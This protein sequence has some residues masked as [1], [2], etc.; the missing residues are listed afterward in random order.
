MPIAATAQWEVRNGGSANNGGF[1][2]SGGT[3]YSQQNAAQ[4][5]LTGVTTSGATDTLLTSSASS[6]MVGNGARIVSGTNFTA[7]FYQII[8]VVAGVS[9]QLDR[10]C[11]TAAGSAGVVNVGGAISKLGDAGSAFVAGNKIWVKGS[12]TLTAIDT[13][14]ATGTITLPIT[15]EGYNATR[16][17]GYQ[18]RNS[19]GELIVSNFPTINYNGNFGLN[20]S[21]ANIIVKCLNVTSIR[22]NYAVTAAWVQ[23]CKVANSSTSV[24]AGC[25][26]SSFPWDNDFAMTGASGGVAGIQAST[27]L[28]IA[29]RGTT[30][31]TAAVGIALQGSSRQ[32]MALHNTLYDCGGAGISVAG[33]T[34][35]AFIV[36]NTIQGGAGDGINIVDSSTVFALIQNN[37]ITD[38]GGWAIDLNNTSTGAIVKHNRFRDNVSGQVNGGSQLYTEMVFGNVTTDT[39]GPETDYVDAAGLDFRLIASSPAVSVAIPAAMSMGALQRDQTGGGGPSGLVGRLV[40]S[41][42]LLG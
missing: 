31:N 1:Y 2:V 27:G 25:I 4:Y 9:I 18:G 32:S 17:D 38:N 40:N 15:I 6:D 34:T 16:G 41:N 21:G 28:A 24:S 5:A 23:W 20:A 30:G 39:G 12:F 22:Q 7:G 10:V 37:I 11:A 33:T 19:I 35:T 42:A 29:N 3:D 26:N 14:S 36:G 13:V 8:A